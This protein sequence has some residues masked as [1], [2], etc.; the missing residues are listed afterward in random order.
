VCCGGGGLCAG[1]AAA[2]KLSGWE[3]TQIYAVE[4]KNGM[5]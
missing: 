1:V 3:N 5:I 4:A 2:L